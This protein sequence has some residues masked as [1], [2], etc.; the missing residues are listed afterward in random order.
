MKLTEKHRPVDMAGLIGQD[1]ISRVVGRLVDNE[2]LT[3]RAYY[4]SGASG[5]G[6]TTLARILADMVADKD[7]IREVVGRQLTPNM[8]KDITWG[9]Q[10]YPM[11]TKPGQVLIVNESHGL[12][13]PVIEIFLD[14]LENL[15]DNILVIFTTTKDGADLFEDNLDSIP[16]ASRCID[17]KFT[18]RG[19]CEPFADRLKEIA[20]LEGLGG[21]DLDKYKK[22]LKN[23]RNN[24][25][26]ALMA[27]DAGQMMG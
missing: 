22:L 14:V 20:E 18:T 6:K 24:F 13:K 26:S 12:T 27:I 21:A 15:P 19:L 7:Y 1:K 2:D 16:F 17:L 25:R 23:N 5:T 11:S 3:G 10:L 8:I 4:I 9:W